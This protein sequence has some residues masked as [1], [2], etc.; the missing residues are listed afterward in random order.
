MARQ[1]TSALPRR[2]ESTAVLSPE[3]LDQG[4]YY[5]PPVDIIETAEEFIFQADLPGVK[6]EDVD[7]RYDNG[8]LTIR[9]TPRHRRTG[10][11]R[12]CLVREYAVAPFYRSFGIDAAI[13]AEGI[14]AELRNGELTLHV[15]KMDAARPRKIAISPA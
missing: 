3:A 8:A 6:P 1:N 4:V 5:T 9:A 12:S 7:V 15:P 14:K 10:E 2:E 11:E 13:R